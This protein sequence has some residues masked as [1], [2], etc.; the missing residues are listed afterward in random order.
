MGRKLVEKTKSRVKLSIDPD[1]LEALKDSGVNQSRLY[2]IAA[3]K[4]LRKKG[5]K[6]VERHITFLLAFCIFKTEQIF[7]TPNIRS[8]K[9][10]GGIEKNAKT[11][12]R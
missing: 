4:Y 1:L 3:K 2:S 8:Y 6:Q 7:E 11:I 12:H 10:I 9:K 5:K